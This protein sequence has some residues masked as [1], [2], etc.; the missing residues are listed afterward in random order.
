MKK[1]IVFDM[2]FNKGIIAE[3]E[4]DCKL[5]D[6]YYIKVAGE[7]YNQ[8]CVLV[9]TS[10]ARCAVELCVKAM[11]AANSAMSYTNLMSGR[12]ISPF[13]ATK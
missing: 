1:V 10:E 5:V 4:S 6:K 12:L 13:I 11:T 8:H 9:D 7:L 3:G 2:A